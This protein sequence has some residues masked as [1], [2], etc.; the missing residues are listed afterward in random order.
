MTVLL[1]PNSFT[2]RMLHAM[3]KER[4]LTCCWNSSEMKPSTMEIWKTFLTRWLLIAARS[5][6]YRSSIRKG[7]EKVWTK[8]RNWPQTS[9]KN[10]KLTCRRLSKGFGRPLWALVLRL[11]VQQPEMVFEMLH[12]TKIW[13][14]LEFERSEES[15]SLLWLSRIGRTDLTRRRK[16][17]SE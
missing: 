16:R 14:P 11:E 10:E 9:Q 8:L 15:E 3:R 2:V 13:K 1:T 4:F 17:F 12:Y 6:M 7:L 5:A